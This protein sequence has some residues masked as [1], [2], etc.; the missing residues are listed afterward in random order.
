METTPPSARALPTVQPARS[1]RPHLMPTTPH[2]GTPSKGHQDPHMNNS[3]VA[4]AARIN[5]RK[6]GNP[7]FKAQREA[8]KR[9]YPLG[10]VLDVFAERA[11]SGRPTPRTSSNLG[12][13][14]ARDQE[15][16]K[17]VVGVSAEEFQSLFSERLRTLADMAVDRIQEKLAEGGQKLGDLNMTLAIS[18]DKLAAMNSK[19][20]QGNLSVQINNYGDMSR[21]ELLASLKGEK[22]V[23]DIDVI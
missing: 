9:T 20:S 1:P 23:I 22:K 7:N 13:M 4:V 2:Q 10:D 12:P 21:D 3:P 14:T 8:T 6:G 11:I 15:M 17:R 19:P 16:I 18:V 5:G